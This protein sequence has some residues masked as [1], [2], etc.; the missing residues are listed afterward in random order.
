M[1]CDDGIPSYYAIMEMI[2]KYSGVAR[3]QAVP[4]ING[5]Y[6]KEIDYMLSLIQKNM[7]KEYAEKIKS[8]Y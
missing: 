4:E 5:I 6:N 8:A 7:E 3:K 2:T 1:K